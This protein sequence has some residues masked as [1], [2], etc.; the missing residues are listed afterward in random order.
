MRARSLTLLLLLAVL[1]ATSGCIS[2]SVHE[3]VVAKRP[4]QMGRAATWLVDVSAAEDTFLPMGLEDA[5]VRR[6]REARQGATTL[7][8]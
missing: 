2:S 4:A 1:L 8:L 5:V 7:M 6:V 3:P